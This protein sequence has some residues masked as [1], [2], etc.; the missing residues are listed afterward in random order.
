MCL[1]SINEAALYP[2]IEVTLNDILASDVPAMVQRVVEV[3]RQ[4][5]E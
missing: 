4:I 2:L 3:H 5:Y 1:I